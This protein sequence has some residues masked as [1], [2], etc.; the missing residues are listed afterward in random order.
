M[1]SFEQIQYL[2][3][4]L[5]PNVDASFGDVPAEHPSVCLAHVPPKIPAFFSTHFGEY[6]V[7]PVPSSEGAS[8]PRMADEALTLGKAFELRTEFPECVA[9]VVQPPTAWRDLFQYFDPHDIWVEGAGF[10]FFVL[11]HLILQNRMKQYTMA[12]AAAEWL[13]RNIDSLSY[14]YEYQ[15]SIG[16]VTLEECVDTTGLQPHEITE[17]AKIVQVLCLKTEAFLAEV[18]GVKQAPIQHTPYDPRRIVPSDTYT[19]RGSEQRFDHSNGT[20]SGAYSSAHAPNDHCNAISYSRRPQCYSEHSQYSAYDNL[21]GGHRLKGRDYSSE[22]ARPGETFL[23]LPPEAFTNSDRLPIISVTIS[24]PAYDRPYQDQRNSVPTSHQKPYSDDARVYDKISTRIHATKTAD[25]GCFNNNP[26]GIATYFGV[27]GTIQNSNTIH[28]ST[29]GDSIRQ[30]GTDIVVKLLSACGNIINCYV[31]YTART[32][33]FISFDNPDSASEAIQRFNN[34]DLGDGRLLRVSKK[35]TRSRTGLNR[36]MTQAGLQTDIWTKH[37]SGNMNDSSE[38]VSPLGDDHMCFSSPPEPYAGE[39]SQLMNTTLSTADGISHDQSLGNTKHADSTVVRGPEA[40][41][42]S[43]GNSRS[44]DIAE[45]HVFF[46]PRQKI[47]PNRASD[48]SATRSDSQRYPSCDRSSTTSGK[49]K[50][51]GNRDKQVTS[52]RTKTTPSSTPQKRDSS[53]ASR[54]NSRV[55]LRSARN[56]FSSHRTSTDD[57]GNV[58]HASM[59]GNPNTL[60]ETLESKENINELLTT[61]GTV[62]DASSNQ[63]LSEKT[64]LEFKGVHRALD[65]ADQSGTKNRKESTV[66]ECSTKK[67]NYEKSEGKGDTVKRLA[68]QMTGSSHEAF[69]TADIKSTNMPTNQ[70]RYPESQSEANGITS[71]ILPDSDDLGSPASTQKPCAKSTVFIEIRGGSTIP[72]DKSEEVVDANDA[73][74]MQASTDGGY[75]N[76]DNRENTGSNNSMSQTDI[77]QKSARSGRKSKSCPKSSSQLRSSTEI[78][79]G[80]KSC[81]GGHNSSNALKLED[82]SIW[83]ELGSGKRVQSIRQSVAAVAESPPQPSL[84][85]DLSPRTVKT[86]SPQVSS[87]EQERPT[88]AQ[89]AA[90]TTKAVDVESQFL[91]GYPMT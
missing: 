49:N 37:S 17:L 80:A 40:C 78:Q 23:Q 66:A 75:L 45:A 41:A 72:L 56:S 30:V 36:D 81:Y 35:H 20:R 55:R 82:N 63:L 21:E 15:G 90:K 84:D 10:L 58:S 43:R 4:I 26:N 25:S 16:P 32:Y 60:P 1:F 51:S 62:Q 48:I 11:K 8:V 61:T 27:P 18:T 71:M 29:G 13:T 33:A 70:R 87:S 12:R 67:P 79:R 47:V 31:P 77:I 22:C 89:I 64:G 7:R 53:R 44:P 54:L 76:E 74:V 42:E 85:E 24:G 57:S 9:T 65:R 59:P 86:R 2:W 5:V 69:E 91:M 28:V 46:T 6:P 68:D 83:P 3:D 73:E 14:E 88:M 38:D 19:F 39:Q 50:A 52:F 34:Y